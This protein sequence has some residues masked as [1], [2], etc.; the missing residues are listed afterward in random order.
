M[1]GRIG[2]SVK[3]TCQS[4][5]YGLSNDSSLG[6]NMLSSR[7]LIAHVS[8][9]PPLHCGIASFASDIITATPNFRHARYALLY[10]DKVPQRLAGFAIAES[11]KAI[12]ELARAISQ[13]DCSVVSIQHE[14]GIWGGKEGENIHEFLDHITKPMVTVLHTTFDPDM[15]SRRQTEI[16]RRLVE[17]SV[18]T[19]VFTRAAKGNVEL[20]SGR[21]MER[22]VVIPHGVPDVPFASP[23]APWTTDSQFPLRALRLIT[24]GFIREDKGI[25]AVLRAVHALRSRGLYVEY[26]IV[27]EP[28]RQFEEQARYFARMNQLVSDLGLQDSVTIERGY[29]S[30]KAQAAAIKWAHAGIFAYRDPR[31]ASS[32]AVPLV[33]AMG[34]PTICTPFEYAIAKHSEEPGVVLMEGFDPDDLAAAIRKF[35]SIESYADLA[36]Q[37]YSRMR[38]SIWPT[39][40]AKFSALWS[41]TMNE[42]QGA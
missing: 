22:V 15:R 38:R 34:R 37:C 24:P 20:A 31:Q 29:L 8:T 9:F 40:G 6:I 26:R 5:S 18:R 16:I 27:G 21:R 30:P 33:L 35:M 19:V 32:G 10:D 25:E 17:Q 13:S 4:S 11:R 39:A 36:K 23:P 7:P 1:L 12:G 2:R 42:A 14:F 3:S 41:S 28:Q